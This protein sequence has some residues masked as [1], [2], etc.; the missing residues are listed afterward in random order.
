MSTTK[1][2]GCNDTSQWKDAK[3]SGGTRNELAKAV[4]QIRSQVRDEQKIFSVTSS[5][6][7][8]KNKPQK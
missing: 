6:L 3:V 4:A 2:L 5:S 8:S 1:F 7:S